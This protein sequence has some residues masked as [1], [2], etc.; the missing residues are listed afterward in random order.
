MRK[1]LEEAE[2]GPWIDLVFGANSRGAKAQ[3]CLNL[4]QGSVYGEYNPKM[5]SGQAKEAYFER[6]RWFGVA[7]IQ[8]FTKRNACRVT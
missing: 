5:M 7:P 3:Q 2:L 6:L 4:Y 8:L 1:A